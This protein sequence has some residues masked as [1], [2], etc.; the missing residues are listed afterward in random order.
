MCFNEENHSNTSSFT[1][2]WTFLSSGFTSVWHLNR[3]TSY[4]HTCTL[5][6]WE[7][8]PF[9]WLQAFCTGSLELG[10]CAKTQGMRNH[11]VKA[12]GCL[13]DSS[14]VARLLAGKLISPAFITNGTGQNSFKPKSQRDCYGDLV[15]ESVPCGLEK[16]KVCIRWTDLDFVSR[17]KSLN[18][19][20]VML[21]KFATIARNV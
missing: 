12:L 20:T 7:Q 16:H 5:D 2:N 9:L 6:H 15:L 8:V 3:N 17:I 14:C 21:P 13:S 18:I 4:L 10:P 11:R 1:W 19:A